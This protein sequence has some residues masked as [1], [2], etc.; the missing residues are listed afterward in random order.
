MLTSERNDAGRQV[1]QVSVLGV[2]VENTTT[3]ARCSAITFP[4]SFSSKI[5]VPSRYIML[6]ASSGG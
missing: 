2:A 4:K 5:G 6:P 3:S 1:H